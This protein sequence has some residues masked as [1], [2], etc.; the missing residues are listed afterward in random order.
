[1]VNPE[2]SKKEVGQETNPDIDP[3]IAATQEV[4]AKIAE[5]AMTPEEKLAAGAK[6]ALDAAREGGLQKHA[7]EIARRIKKGGYSS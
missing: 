3:A 7:K 1:M 2:D 6:K 4:L 5:D